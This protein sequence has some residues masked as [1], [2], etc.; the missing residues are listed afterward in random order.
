MAL[1][2][3]DCR[4]NLRRGSWGRRKPGEAS[5]ISKDTSR[6]DQVWCVVYS[7]HINDDYSRWR[8]LMARLFIYELKV[9]DCFDVPVVVLSNTVSC[10]YVEKCKTTLICISS[11]HNKHHALCTLGN[12]C[13]PTWQP[14]TINLDT[15]TTSHLHTSPQKRS[16]GAAGIPVVKTPT[17]VKTEDQKPAGTTGAAYLD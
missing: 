15:S 7:C 13:N 10:D 4:E 16:R 8:S 5:R 3:F 1:L 12:C 9:A 14:H 11:C 17:V 6:H 2:V